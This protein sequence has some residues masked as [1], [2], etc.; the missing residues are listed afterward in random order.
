MNAIETQ[1]KKQTELLSK[2]IDKILKSSSAMM[3]KFV[4]YFDGETTVADTHEQCFINAEE[5][6]GG[7]GFAI[8]EVAPTKKLLVSALIKF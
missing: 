1:V 5:K 8:A 4:A 6:F 3:G 2:E 7:K